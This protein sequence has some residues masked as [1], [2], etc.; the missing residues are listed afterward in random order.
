MLYPGA[1]VLALAL[2]VVTRPSARR[3]CVFWLV[4]ILATLIFALGSYLPPLEWFAHLPGMDLLRVPP[5]VL[6]G[7]AAKTLRQLRLPGLT[8][9]L[10]VGVG[11]FIATRVLDAVGILTM[12]VYCVRYIGHRLG[13]QLGLSS[14]SG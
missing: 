8:V 2:Y 10:I 4:L 9:L 5:R 13:A 12:V 14:A 1:I 6:F 7:A 3:R 11:A